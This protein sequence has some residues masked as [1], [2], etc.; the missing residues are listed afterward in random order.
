MLFYFSLIKLGSMKGVYAVHPL[1]HAW[2]RDRMSS[3]DRQKYCLM[4]Y[5]MLAQS[6]SKSF[7][8]QPYQFRRILVN[9][10]RAN[11]QHSVVA[12]KE[13]VGSYFDDAHEKFGKMLEEQGYNS[14]AEKFLILV[15]EA[16]TR[17]LGEDHLATIRAMSHLANTYTSLGK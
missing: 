12:K 9:H 1:I 10:L 2:G 6:L 14:E 3:E 8:E 16:R 5:V 11:I 7:H 4:A 17:T 15:L 13:M